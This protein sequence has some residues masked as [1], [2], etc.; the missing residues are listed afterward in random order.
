[1][2][3]Q[4]QAPVAPR[5][6]ARLFDG[7][8]NEALFQMGVPAGLVPLIRTFRTEDEFLERSDRFGD[9]VAVRLLD[10]LLPGPAGPVAAADLGP[11]GEQPVHAAPYR[12][13]GVAPASSAS[14]PAHASGPGRDVV[15][16][17]A[18]APRKPG[19]RTRGA[20]RWRLSPTAR[21]MTRL[22][23][24]ASLAALIGQDR[25]RDV[26]ERFLAIRP[27]GGRV[28]V[29]AEGNAVTVGDGDD[30]YLGRVEG[31]GSSPALGKDGDLLA[32]VHDV[33]LE[34]PDSTAR[35]VAYR[36]G[37]AGRAVSRAQVNAV[38]YAR[39]TRFAKDDGEVPRWRVSTSA[40]SVATAT[41]DGRRP[42]S[43]EVSGPDPALAYADLVAAPGGTARVGPASSAPSTP[44]RDVPAGVLRLMAWQQEAV[45]SWYLHGCRGVIEAVTGTGKTHV[46]LEVVAHAAAE[47]IHSTVL[48]PSVDLQDQWSARLRTFLPHLRVARVGG[49][50]MGYPTNA[51]VV[52]AVVNSAMKHDL[53]ELSRDSLIVAD[54][55]H[56][57]GAEGFRRA[58]REGYVR[59][60]GLTAT[61]ERGDDAIEEVLTPYF[62]STR[63]KVGFD[64]AIR[65]GVVAPFRLVLAPVDL[66][67][68]ER[69]EY[70][71]L[72]HQ[73]SSG[74]KVLKAAGVLQPGGSGVG[75]QLGRLR[76]LPGRIGGAARSAEAAM[77]ARR[78][79]LA[80]LEGKLDAV[81]ELAD[82]VA[83]SRGAVIFTQSTE[84][85]EEAAARLR[86]WGVAASALHS[87]MDRV[88]RRQALEGLECGRLRALAAPRLLDEGIDVPTVDLGIVMTASRS[89]RQMV[90]RLGRVI[91][92]KDDGTAVT[93]VILYAAGTVEDP[94]SGVHEGFFDLVGE[95]A[96]DRL[97]LDQDWTARDISTSGASRS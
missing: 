94:S 77:R 67:A 64:R 17:S 18:V 3:T 43:P 60:L 97:E 28:W 66:L 11:A 21:T 53:S 42:R 61:L 4:S 54:E 27:S 20:D 95:V 7:L 1:M 41:S 6:S 8:E 25:A 93:F 19:S 23:D 24:G 65:E 14:P 63:L 85:A 5:A 72:S 81:E 38:L 55:V 10:H 76:A 2:T 50:A 57:Y 79:L 34:V 90:Q 62:G 44:A 71:A 47:R 56:R 12:V 36:L 89:R 49:S 70:E 87:D 91:R 88:E 39:P 84:V 86:E 37:N 29:D 46:G 9:E 92:R 31:V 58:L 78:L 33:L 96:A 16:G 80:G 51:E 75:H 59:R 30:V 22:A 74:L 26:V 69:A 15:R 35:E 32:A 68:E 83:S 40:V 48:V 82:V 73:I 52:V 45:K 13:G